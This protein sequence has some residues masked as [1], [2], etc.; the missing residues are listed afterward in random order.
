MKGDT[1][2][3]EKW[4]RRKVRRKEGEKGCKQWRRGSIGEEGGER[5]WI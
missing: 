1:L 5:R 2:E 3:E 4:V